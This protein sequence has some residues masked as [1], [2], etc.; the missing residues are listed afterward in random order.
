MSNEL[1]ESHCKVYN[2]DATS[3]SSLDGTLHRLTPTPVYSIAAS[4]T[5]DSITLLYYNMSYSID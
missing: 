5:F 3:R 4:I 1:M 2:E